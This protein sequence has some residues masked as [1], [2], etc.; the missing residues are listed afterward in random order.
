MARTLA[1]GSHP[2]S[3]IGKPDAPILQLRDLTK[4]YGERVAVNRLTLDIWPGEIF[5]F[6]GP[7]GAGKT[8]TIRMCLGLITP[9]TGSVTILGEEVS[10][11][12]TH[13][14]SSVG[15]L[16]EQPAV[17][18]YLSGRDNLRVMA[19]ALGGIPATRLDEVLDLV[20]LHDRAQDR[21]Q[22]YS[23]G[24]KQRLGIALALLS[25]PALLILDEPANGLDPAGIV[26]IRDLLRRLAAEGKT[27]FLSSHVLGE[28]QQISTRVGII[29][30]GQLVVESTVGALIQ[31]TGEFLV[32]VDR[33][34]EALALVR[35]QSW[36]GR[37]RLDDAQR[38][39]TRAPG[40]QSGA[41]NL[42]L[43]NA[44]FVP[45]AITPATETLEE[46]FLRLTQ[47]PTGG[48]V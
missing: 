48:N 16:V 10:P 36:G 32:T 13:I 14:L 29:R 8:T 4:R 15:A 27:I 20:S 47:S 12:Q 40:D 42:F 26:E 1:P 30:Q 23:L 45:G 3:R 37:A 9:T 18:P 41:L 44:G 21:V 38:L 25:D 28:V 24:M 35:M 19:D 17:Y 2:T 31:G 5:G 6:L 22:R 39:V 46:I 43:V 7:N 34:R 11:H 33:P